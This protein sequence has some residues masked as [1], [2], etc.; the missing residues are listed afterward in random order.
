MDRVDAAGLKI[1]RPLHDFV[2][3]EAAPGTG[4]DAAAFWEGFAALIRDLGPRNRELLTRRDALQAQID[5]WHLRNRGKPADHA[6]YIEFLR[7]IGYLQPEPADFAVGTTGVDPEIATIAGPQLVVPVTNARYALNA[8]NARWGSLYDALYGTDALPQDTAPTLQEGTGAAQSGGL[9]K[10]RA[11]RVV[12]RAR[13]ILDQA[14]PLAKGSY[15]NAVGFAIE[16][17]KLSVALQN[18][19]N[20]GLKDPAQ[21][22]GYQGDARFAVSG[23][24]EA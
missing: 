19:G 2:A 9:N 5:D 22:A 18:G 17:G 7:E 10:V 20:T 13:E 11:A 8:A 16:G 15:G 3:T 6:G 24:A 12:A 4:V 14:V 23:T 1:A 21:L